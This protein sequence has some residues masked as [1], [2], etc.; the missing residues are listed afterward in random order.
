MAKTLVYTFRRVETMFGDLEH[1]D[2]DTIERTH[3]YTYDNLINESQ[4][5]RLWARDIGLCSD[6]HSLLELRLQD[7]HSVRGYIIE[8]LEDLERLL[9]LSVFLLSGLENN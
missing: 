6:D 4:R 1:Q 8:L 2:R 5:F 7:A 9:P 3:S